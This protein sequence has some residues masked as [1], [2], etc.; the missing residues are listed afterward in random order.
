MSMKLW[1]LQLALLAIVHARVVDSIWEEEDFA[2]GGDTSSENR[3]L[4]ASAGEPAPPQLNL[5]PP[6]PGSKYT[7]FDITPF[8]NTTCLDTVYGRNETMKVEKFI[9]VFMSKYRFEA[10]VSAFCYSQLVVVASYMSSIPDPTNRPSM[11]LFCVWCLTYVAQLC[12]TVC[13]VV[14]LAISVSKV[15]AGYKDCAHDFGGSTV[16]A[17]T[18]FFSA[19]MHPTILAIVT[20]LYA[21]GMVLKVGADG[22]ESNVAG[23]LWVLR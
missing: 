15:N 13:M 12:A 3:F 18:A 17:Y 5:S 22:A 1:V 9:D 7:A 16:L 4:G 8:F 20:S 14:V 11:V 10:T 2:F 6:P 21:G 23:V 19:P